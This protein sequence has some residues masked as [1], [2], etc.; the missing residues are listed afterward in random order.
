MIRNVACG[1]VLVC[2]G[3]VASAQDVIIDWNNALLNSVAATATAPPPASRMMAML[4]TAQFD[5][6]NS[7]E[8]GYTPYL[9]RIKPGGA[10]SSEA[11]AAQAAH[12]VL[13]H[14]YPARAADYAAQLNAH[15]SLIA[16]GDEKTRGLNVGATAA[17]RIIAQRANDGSTATVPYTPG[18][19]PGDWKPTPPAFNGPAFPQWPTVTP[20]AM[21]SGSQ[22]R[23][24]APPSLTSQEYTDA[25]NEVKEL[26][27]VDSATRTADQ[28]EIALIWAANAGTVTPPGQFNQIAQ[29]VVTNNGASL[30]EK[31][32]TF[33]LVGMSVADAAIVAWDAKYT[34]DFWRPITG[35][36]EADTDLNPDT[37]QDATWTPFIPTPPFQAYT[38]GHSSFSGSSAEM[39]ALL[40]G[41][42]QSFSLESV[43]LMR[44]FSSLT[45]AAEE[46]GQSRIYGG[47]HWQFDNTA[48]LDSGRALAHYIYGNFLQVPAPT[49]AGLLAL[50]GLVATRRRR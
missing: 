35:I 27:R 28:S 8:G 4:H 49:S 41:D 31:A 1:M 47:I 12:D 36:Q 22:F 20:W 5:A 23:P 13:V 14:L 29:Q 3:A 19:N 26:G 10:A 25:F 16:D 39:L 6:V 44:N 15:L 48:A 11:A 33:A 32:R 17:A 50:G 24:P 34:Y 18:G 9:G 7:I 37:I 40:F 38:S 46:A 21:N 45:E 42:A 43:G 30:A 2:A